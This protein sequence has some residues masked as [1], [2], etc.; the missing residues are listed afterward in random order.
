MRGASFIL[1]CSRHDRDPSHAVCHVM[2]GVVRCLFFP[3]V[4]FNST[5]NTET[6]STSSA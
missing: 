6:N 3:F 5:F 2:I 1:V 4:S